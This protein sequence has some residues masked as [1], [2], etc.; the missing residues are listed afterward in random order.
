MVSIVGRN[1]AYE[2]P[3]AMT[4]WPP[5][6][7]PIAISYKQSLTRTNDHALQY[8]GLINVIYYLLQFLCFTCKHHPD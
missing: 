5:V 2:P 6:L 7:R 3:L 1:P 8:R 4:S